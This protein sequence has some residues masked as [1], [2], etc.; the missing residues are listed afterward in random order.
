MQNQSTKSVKIITAR[1]TMIQIQQTYL[2]HSKAGNGRLLAIFL[3]CPLGTRLSSFR[4]RYK[5]FCCT[6]IK[7]SPSKVSPTVRYLKNQPITGVR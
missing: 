3:K 6:D 4:S 7:S 2:K 1:G 5:R